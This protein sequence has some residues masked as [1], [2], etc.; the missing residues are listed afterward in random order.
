MAK[1]S[2]VLTTMSIDNSAGALNVLVNDNLS[3]EF[4]TPRAAQDTTGADKTAMERILLLGDF[5]AQITNAFNDAADKTHDTFK[6]VCS[7]AVTRTMTI[8]VS[9]QT[10]TNEVLLLD[11]LHSRWADGSY[12]VRSNAVLQDGTAPTWS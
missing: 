1:E 7:A 2:P 5:S 12:T 9:G 3:L 11:Y 4:A 8:V 10:L 6:T